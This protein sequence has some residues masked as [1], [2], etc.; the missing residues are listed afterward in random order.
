MS[1]SISER[2]IRQDHL[3]QCRL[4]RSIQEPTGS[5]GDE[6]PATTNVPHPMARRPEDVEDGNGA[7]FWL[8]AIGSPPSQSGRY[9]FSES[10]TK[11]PRNHE[12][13]SV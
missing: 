5:I 13:L 9:T 3:S 8:H 2:E 10:C 1:G 12:M 11:R 6:E 4:H 7:T